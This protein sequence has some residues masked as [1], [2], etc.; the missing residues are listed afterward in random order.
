MGFFLPEVQAHFRWP[1]ASPIPGRTGQ[2]RIYAARRVQD[3]ALRNGK[4]H[5]RRTAAD[6]HAVGVVSMGISG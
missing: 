3:A 5:M 2:E 1:N 4:S 6:A